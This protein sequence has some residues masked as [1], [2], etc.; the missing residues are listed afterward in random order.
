MIEQALALLR[1]LRRARRRFI[2]HIIFKQA[3]LASSIVIGAFILLLLLG[4][5]VLDWYWSVLLLGGALAFGAWRTWSGIPSLYRLAQLLDSR[6]GLHDTLSTAYHF[7]NRKVRSEP[8][9]STCTAASPSAAT[10]CC[11]SAGIAPPPA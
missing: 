7:R 6:L 3:A 9:R 8:A 10:C 2:G 1:L 5:Q 4:T 11:D